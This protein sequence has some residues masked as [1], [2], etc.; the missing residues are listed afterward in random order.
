MVNF[1]IF[2]TPVMDYIYFEAIIWNLWSLEFLELFWTD[3]L[4]FSVVRGM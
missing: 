1:W 3:I 2:T 4:L